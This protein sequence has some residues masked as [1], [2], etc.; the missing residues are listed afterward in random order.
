MS[1]EMSPWR[2]KEPEQQSLLQGLGTYRVGVSSL[3]VCTPERLIFGLACQL[4]GLGV[5]TLRGYTLGRTLE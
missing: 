4:L 1:F 3:G 5:Y 2:R